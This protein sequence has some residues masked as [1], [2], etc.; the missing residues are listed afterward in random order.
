MSQKARQTQSKAQLVLCTVVLLLYVAV[1]AGA[2]AVVA[3]VVGA[4]A[5]VAVVAV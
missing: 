2:V 1:V 3:V 4:V 5:V